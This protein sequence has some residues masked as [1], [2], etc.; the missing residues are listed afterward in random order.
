MNWKRIGSW[1][2][3]L[4][5]IQFV[6]ITFIIMIP[7]PGG[8]SFLE[9]SFSSLGLSIT[10]GVP[11]PL[12]WFMFATATTLAGGLS[13]PFWLSIRT[14]FEET[15]SLKALSWIGTILGV[16]AGPLLAGV[17]I[18][19][20][21]VYPDQHGFSTIYFFLLFSSAI[22]I[23][24]IA[25]LLN[26]DYENAYALI[27]VIVAIICYTYVLVPGFGNAAMQKLAVY[28]L[29]L[30]SVFQGHKLLKVF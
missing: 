5:G 20:G 2:G 19:A 8:Y 3:I 24:S 6:I 18:F 26:K 4:A 14:L 7:Y 21:D 25:I 27:G 13:I 11:T 12:N 17:G 16:I 10:N 15:T 28:S 30:Y 29:V 9:N 23:Y 22:I 1:C